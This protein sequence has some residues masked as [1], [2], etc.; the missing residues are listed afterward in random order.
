MKNETTRNSKPP[1]DRGAEEAVAA[2]PK[3]ETTANAEQAGGQPQMMVP[4]YVLMIIYHYWRTDG[5]SGIDRVY[6]QGVADLR[7]RAEIE[8]VEQLILEQA[9]GGL[10]RV[11]ISNWR[12][13][14]G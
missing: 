6:M 12:T 13:L 1:I 2:D 10:A 4:A 11:M 8:R 3:V 14:E 5:T 7:R 9:Q